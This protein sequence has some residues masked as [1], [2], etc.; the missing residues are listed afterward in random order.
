MALSTQCVKVGHYCIWDR[1]N[2]YAVLRYT[3]SV[4]LKNPINFGRSHQWENGRILN[5]KSLEDSETQE[6]QKLFGLIIKPNRLR[7][8]FCYIA[9]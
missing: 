5:T 3:R 6:Q 2:L 1:V 8:V 9:E 7:G 4:K